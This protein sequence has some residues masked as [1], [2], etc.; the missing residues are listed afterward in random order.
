MSDECTLPSLHV[1]TGPSAGGNL[2]VSEPGC[3]LFCACRDVCY[4][5]LSLP[6]L[7]Y[8]IPNLFLPFVCVPCELV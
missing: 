8:L 2:L 6:R 1:T 5:A 3:V 4:T 7:C